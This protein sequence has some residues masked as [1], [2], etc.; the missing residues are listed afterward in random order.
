MTVVVDPAV[1]VDQVE[2]K[3]AAV[4]VNGQFTI[5]R[6]DVGVELE[7]TFSGV[8][9]SPFDRK[10]EY[11]YLLAKSRLSNLLMPPDE[12]IDYRGRCNKCGQPQ[13]GMKFGPLRYESAEWNGDDVVHCDFH[14]RNIYTPK[15]FKF[16]K[17]SGKG[18][19]RSG[20]VL[21]Q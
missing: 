11:Y 17:G 10:Q 14:S 3:K 18:I 20:I 9:L 15:A 2:C 6:R 13:F 8:V 19:I 1:H 21:L 7:K 16:L 12:V 5:V 4:T